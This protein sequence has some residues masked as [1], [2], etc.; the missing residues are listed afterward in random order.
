MA[1]TISQKIDAFAKANLQ[2]LKQEEAKTGRKMTKFDIAQ[3]MLQKGKLNKNEYAN[4]MNT[5]E[6]FNAQAMTQQQKTALKQG[7][8]WGFSGYG[9]GEESYLDSMTSFSQKTPVEKQNAISHRQM[10]LNETV[11]ERKK[12][13]A[14]MNNYIKN[15]RILNHKKTAAE[16]QFKAH[17]DSVQISE[18]DANKTASQLTREI[19]Q[20]KIDNMSHDERKKFIM[21][22]FQDAAA[23]K[24]ASGMAS[25]LSEFNSYMCKYIDDKVGVTDVKNAIKEYSGL[26]ALVDYV[27]NKVDDGDDTNLSNLERAWNIAKGLGDAVDSFIGAEGVEVVGLLTGAGEVA[28]VAKVGKYFS[29]ATQTYFGVEGG[30]LIG[31]GLAHAQTAETE[32]DARLAGSELGMGTI[33]LG[34]AVKSAKMADKHIAIK[35]HAQEFVKNA[36]DIDLINEFNARTNYG[37]TEGLEIYKNE[38]TKRGFKP[39]ENGYFEAKTVQTNNSAVQ[40]SPSTYRAKLPTPDYSKTRANFPADAHQSLS[41]AGK[42]TAYTTDG[43]PDGI[44]YQGKDGKMYVPNKWDPEHPYEV[45]TGADGKPA[46]VIMIYDE[47]GGD[48]AVGEPTTIASTYKNPATGELDPLYNAQVGKGNA[49]EIVK[50]QVPSAYK[51]VK[52]GTE[53]QTKEGPRVIQ[54][55]EVV[56]YDTD[57][58]PYV[59]PKKNFLKRQEPLKGDAESEA[60]YAK[61]KNN[62]AIPESEI[63]TDGNATKA[64]AKTFEQRDVQLRTRLTEFKGPDG[65]PFL[66]KTEVDNL[67]QNCQEGF[68]TDGKPIPNYEAKIEAVLNNPEEVAS[69]SGWKSRSAGIWRA[70]QDPLSSTVEANPE[71]FGVKPK[72]EVKAGNNTGKTNVG[73]SSIENLKAFFEDPKYECM[74]DFLKNK[75]ILANNDVFKTDI[76][77]DAYGDKIPVIITKIPLKTES[78]TIPA[79]SQLGMHAGTLNINSYKRIHRMSIAD[80]EY[81]R[82]IDYSNVNVPLVQILKDGKR[83]EYITIPLDISKNQAAIAQLDYMTD[84]YAEAGGYYVNAFPDLAAIIAKSAK[85]TKE[86]NPK[87]EVK[88][89]SNPQTKPS[90]SPE[91]RNGLIE[92]LKDVEYDKQVVI[93][94]MDKYPEFV[95]KLVNF[96]VDGNQFFSKKDV[97]DIIYNCLSGNDGL[98]ATPERITDVLNNPNEIQFIQTARSRAAGLW[99]ALF[100]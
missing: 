57:G 96:K 12:K 13:A 67:I 94:T 50:D 97:N 26:N 8:V 86:V 56:V 65:K 15:E 7:N 62:E 1:S 93:N 58:D 4:W 88:V 21:G 42:A 32:E 36:S 34:G 52:E 16:Q 77:T 83:G 40:S 74:S 81:V 82:D 54:Q 59:M 6:G 71:V 95:E 78:G 69:I 20:Q 11:A 55:D 43:K 51:I 48:F 49:M 89:K 38:L 31:A 64:S 87:A 46:S 35:E 68:I 80:P 72:A 5:S 100:R 10:K 70:I 91:I 25:A 2:T 24:D 60:L 73:N 28:A 63:A 27:D 41:K 39:N 23:K 3:Y 45:S 44:V 14:E 30:Q 18:A 19:E 29:A 84:T 37:V 99:I 98:K 33:M 66:S 79:G 22:K 61:L 17:V 9:G 76:I 85:S 92:A 90:I 53:I 47:A 75:D